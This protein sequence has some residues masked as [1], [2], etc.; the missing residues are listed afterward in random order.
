MEFL[1]KSLKAPTK[2][3][4]PLKIPL[5]KRKNWSFAKI[6]YCPNLI[7]E[8]YAM[9]S[10]VPVEKLHKPSVPPSISRLTTTNSTLSTSYQSILQQLRG[11]ENVT[12]DIVNTIFHA[13]GYKLNILHSPRNS[14]ITTERS[15]TSWT[16]RK[17]MKLLEYFKNFVPNATHD[18]IKDLIQASDLNG[19]ATQDQDQA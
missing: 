9:C 19:D 4:A 1:Q 2:V 16:T 7:N 3:K 5:S 10:S 17:T 15:P 13:E 6:K 12:L 8:K 11:N 14:K 18:Q